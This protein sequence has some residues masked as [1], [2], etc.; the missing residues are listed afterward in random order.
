MRLNFVDLRRQ[1]LSYK[2]EI[3][4]AIDKVLN[5]TRFI[6]GPE[7]KELEEQLAAY[8]GV[9]HAIGV[10]SGTDALLLALM[11]YDIKP[12]DEII[13]TPFSFI[14]TAE[15]ISLLKAK[16]VFADIEDSTYNLDPAKI[17]G[18]IEQK[19]KTEEFRI[20]GIIAVSLYGQCADF[21]ALNS[22]AQKHNLFVLEDACQS[23]GATYKGRRSCSLTDV[24]ATSF[25]PSK[26]LGCYGDGGMVFTGDDSLAGKVRHL[27]EHGSQ[28]RYEHKYVGLNSR[29]DT[30]Q[31]AVLLAKFRHFEDELI[32]RQ[33]CGAYYTEK[34]KDLQ[35]T[36]IPPAILAHNKSVYAQYS[37]RVK[38]RDHLAESLKKDGIPTAIHYPKPLHLQTALDYL[39]HRPGDFP[40]SES[41][42]GGILSLPMH[43]FLTEDEQSF[44]VDR[45]AAALV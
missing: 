28:E 7:I 34:L 13:T 40:V 8:V 3:D 39:G 21:D 32:L 1:Y 6:M 24:A 2:E 38:R 35:P 5:S 19:K 22:I 16:P 27:R 25:F 11:A 33:K 36:V 45:I 42:A 31:A 23:F 18:I 14:A 30:I 17:A 37:I 15:V 10:S 44:I 9:K 20:K 29:L 43:P 4:R 12:G 41:V 26:P